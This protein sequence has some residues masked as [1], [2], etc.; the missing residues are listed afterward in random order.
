MRSM[1]RSLLMATAVTL[2]PALSAADAPEIPIASGQYVFEHRFAEHPTI[3]SI[4][5]Q[6][7]IAGERIVVVN[8][9]AA[10]PF[11]AGTLAE[12]QLM[13]HAGSRQWIIGDAPADASA[14]DVGGC[15]DGPEVVD[16]ANRIYWTC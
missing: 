1:K 11:P 4:R 9:A 16:L 2:A 7:T 6:V 13:W 8:P 5:L 14:P 3:P 10:D 15:S 12:G